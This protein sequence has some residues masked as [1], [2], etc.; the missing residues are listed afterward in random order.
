MK[1]RLL[2]IAL[3]FAM[4]FSLFP[5]V[6]AEGEEAE[7][8]QDAA[9]AEELTAQGDA[10]MS[11]PSDAKSDSV[12]NDVPAGDDAPGGTNASPERGGVSEADGGDDPD[13]DPAGDDAPDVPLDDAD[14]VELETAGSELDVASAEAADATVTASGTCGANGSS[15]SWTFYSDGKLTISGSGAMMDYND[16]NPPWKS[17][18]SSISTVVIS[19]GVTNIGAGAF[20]YCSALTSVTI[21]TSVT[22][23]GSGAFL[24][25]SA[26]TSISIPSS[27]K[28]IG[29]NAFQFCSNLSSL[30]LPS[31]LTSIG[32][33]AFYGCRSLESITIPAAVTSI[34]NSPFVGCIALSAI[35]VSA[36]NPAYCSENGLLFNKGKTVL[37]TCPGGKSGSCVLPGGVTNI[38]KGAF[39]GCSGLTSVTLP[40]SVTSLGQY[41]FSGCSGL[42]N[43]TI[44]ASV[45]VINSYAFQG[46]SGLT[47]VALPAGVSVVNSYTFS[48]CS[49]LTSVTFPAGVTSIGE[50]AFENCGGLTSITLPSGLTSIGSCAFLSCSGLTSVTLR[51]DTASIGSYAFYGCSDLTDVYYSG[52]E[53]AWAEIG[54]ETGNDLLESA[55]I[56]YNAE[57]GSQQGGGT[58]SGSCGADGDSVTW[59]L[60]D[61]GTIVISGTGAM[62]DYEPDTVPWAAYRSEIVSAVIGNGVTNI[63]GNAFSN[64]LCLAE[65][66]I[67]SGVTSIGAYAFDACFALTAVTLPEGVTVIGE[68]AFEGCSSLESISIP[69]SISQIESYAFGSC[70]SLASVAYAGTQEQWNAIDIGSGN[71]RLTALMGSGQSSGTASVVA[72]GGCGP[73]GTSV[74]W[75]LYDNGELVI[76]GSRQMCDYSESQDEAG[77]YNDRA[78]WYGYRSQI[79]TVTIKTGVTS[80][81]AY[82]FYDCYALTSVSIAESVLSIGKMAFSKSGL[83]SVTIPSGVTSISNAAFLNCS[84]L[85]SVELPAGLTAIGNLAFSHSGLTSVTIPSGVTEMGS[86]A[87]SA[88]SLVSVTIQPGV[89]SLGDNTFKDCS[90]L[91]SVTIPGSVEN[92][93][94]NDFS[95]CT[96]LTSVTIE[97][98]VRGIGKYAFRNCSSLSYLSIPSKLPFIGD[99]AFD[100]CS[101]LA[102]VSFGSTQ[103]CRTRLMQSGLWSGTRN[104]ALSNASWS[105]GTDRILDSGAYVY[106]IYGWTLYD[107][108]EL[109]VYRSDS[110]IPNASIPD[111]VPGTSYPDYVPWASYAP[112]ILSAEFESGVNRIIPYAF[113]N[114]SNLGSVTISSSVTS[115]GQHAFQ[116]CSS[117]TSVVIPPSV[118]SIEE[119][120]FYN[121]SSLRSASIPESVTSIPRYC[122]YGCD[123]LR[124]V[125]IPEGVTSI[126]EYAFYNCSNLASVNIPEG[127]TTI[128]EKA[129]SECGALAEITI[130][131]SVTS[132][133][134]YAFKNCSSLAS[135]LLLPSLDSIPAGLFYAC[136]GMTSFA[137]PAGVTSILDS[138]FAYSGLNDVSIPESV[139]RVGDYAFDGCNSL[140]RVYYGGT[141]TGWSSI[142]FGK[143]SSC[144]TSASICYA[145]AFASHSL[146]LTGELGVNFYMDLS[147][148][149]SAERAA[150]SMTFTVDGTEQT[151]VF[152]ASHTNPGGNGYYGFTCTIS[153]VQMAD[154]ITAEFHYGR[155]LSVKQGYSAK[156]YIDYVNQY[157]SGYTA[158][159]RAL[160]ASLASY[161]ANV[162][163]FLAAR[164]GWTLGEAHTA[165]TGG[166]VY[167]AAALDTIR[168]GTSAYAFGKDLGSSQVV[169]VSYSLDLQSKTDLRV[170]FTLQPGYTGAVTATL[171]GSP[172]TAARLSDGRYC[173]TVPSIAAHELGT[174]HTIVLSA[175]GDCTVTVSALSYVDAA[176]RSSSEVFANDTARA[177][178][179]SLYDYYAAAANYLANPAA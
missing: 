154:R 69:V 11:T 82:A 3:C 141:R 102:N 50:R 172:V 84:D 59:S 32:N 90:N 92:I 126:G 131:A 85:Q 135:A 152:D 51:E 35:Q 125:S 163:P 72:D 164:N 167:D 1:K 145:P 47:S 20:Y 18:Q 71:D 170:F 120:A 174:A 87:F 108:G 80:I 169:K 70:A 56:H 77:Y 57:N 66:A 17:Y 39:Q 122:F 157:P 44:P 111:Y 117:L 79:H 166:V 155:G 168:T 21:P 81:G 140:T 121:C 146:L 100:G 46:C 76:A 129:F 45:S 149:T 41:A 61:G 24:N 177:A 143:N 114:C 158:N 49:G 31:G 128:G 40:A 64:C 161:G 28:S 38:E 8:I 109:H 173:V 119:Y 15:P 86:M 25:C 159:T 133:G 153:S 48:G 29:D 151:D 26:L 5:A 142:N 75:T 99:Y 165:M 104:A 118:T 63:G 93:G 150:C 43:I 65:V 138:A 58:A 7:T 53:A 101:S 52:T 2:S 37:I 112:F 60:L 134:S 19:S 147:Q 33:S 9:V 162:Q 136:T 106:A 107:T 179:A 88:S 103:I 22:N 171:D 36:S 14:P 144:L 105:Y 95:S 73:A 78:P 139:E 83:T 10:E 55:T 124:S 137:I 130:P 4:L 96:S 16:F 13:N 110:P 74:G 160:V 34:G 178:V 67:A 6:Y 115:I 42:T 94:E 62:A 89:S 54:I 27:V 148:M 98:G 175:G 116:N 97:P 132:L 23:I 30:T 156:N 12:D 113:D 176:L 68:S 127:V 123:R 91:T